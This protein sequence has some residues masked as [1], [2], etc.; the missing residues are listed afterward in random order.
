VQKNNFTNTHY[1]LHLL[2]LHG[3]PRY[4]LCI[5]VRTGNKDCIWSRR[6][7]WKYCIQIFPSS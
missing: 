4:V 2:R 7:L 1:I 6:I 5:S 3:V